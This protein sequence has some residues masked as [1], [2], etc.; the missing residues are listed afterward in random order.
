LQDL[1]AVQD[2]I[3][4]PEYC[5]VENT[6]DAMIE[7]G[8][9]FFVLK[10]WYFATR[11]RKGNTSRESWNRKIETLWTIHTHDHIIVH[12]HVHLHT[13]L[14]FSQIHSRS[15]IHFIF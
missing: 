8:E 1:A 6:K 14:T 11:E 3:K 7:A 9:P 4:N 10:R 15:H 13:I 2:T 12:I 5:S